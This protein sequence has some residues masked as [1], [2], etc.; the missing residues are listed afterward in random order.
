MNCKDCFNAKSM[1]GIVRCIY[2]EW[3]KSYTIRSVLQGRIPLLERLP[4]K[5]EHYSPPSKPIEYPKGEMNRKN[6][7]R[8]LNALRDGRKYFDEEPPVSTNAAYWENWE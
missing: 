8:V 7:A 4:Q 1:K 6:I 3:N 5:C 2:G